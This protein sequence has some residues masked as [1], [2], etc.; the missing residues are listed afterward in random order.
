MSWP[1]SYYIK[2]KARSGTLVG[3]GFSAQSSRFESRRDAVDW[4]INVTNIN[5]E[6]NRDVDPN[7]EV[8]ASELEPEI[9]RPS[10]YRTGEKI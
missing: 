8:V 2:M 6:A 1:K 4:A 5:R 9:P 7:Y 3:G 10:Y